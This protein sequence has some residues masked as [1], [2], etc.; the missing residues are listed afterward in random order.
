MEVPTICFATFS[1]TDFPMILPDVPFFL[2]CS[3]SFTPRYLIPLPHSWSV[4]RLLSSVRALGT[5]LATLSLP[6]PWRPCSLRGVGGSSVHG[7]CP[8]Y[9]GTHYRPGYVPSAIRD[10]LPPDASPHIDPI[11]LQ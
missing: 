1:S 11:L 7:W 4:R 2:I 8:I 6:G 10:A 9:A 5:P 3:C